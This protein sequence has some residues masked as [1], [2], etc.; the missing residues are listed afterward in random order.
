MMHNITMLKMSCE[1]LIHLFRIASLEI[2]EGCAKRQ[3]LIAVDG[4]APDRI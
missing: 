4:E 2:I 1:S 3:R